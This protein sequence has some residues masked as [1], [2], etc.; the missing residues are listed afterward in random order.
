MD[1]DQIKA[2]W[3]QFRGKIKEKWDKITDDDLTTVAG[4]RDQ[5]V[6]LLQVKYGY[7]KAQAENA[8]T[9]LARTLKLSPAPAGFI[10][11]PANVGGG[12]PR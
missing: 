7:D 5:L 1:W 11:P 9:D 10:V 2:N 4:K 3:E 6:D 12:N 8:L